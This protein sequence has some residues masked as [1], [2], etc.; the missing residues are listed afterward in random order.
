MSSCIMLLLFFFQA[1]DGIRDYKV[2]GVQTCALPICQRRLYETGISRYRGYCFAVSDRA[3]RGRQVRT[4]SRAAAAGLGDGGTV[5]SVSAGARTLCELAPTGGS[6]AS[7]RGAAGVGPPLRRGGPAGGNGGPH[8]R[9]A[10]HAG[11]RQNGGRANRHAVGSRRTG[12]V[13]HSRTCS[14]P[15]AAGSGRGALGRGER[16][17]EGQPASDSA[18]R[19]EK[20]GGEERFPV[21]EGEEEFLVVSARIR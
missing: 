13:L 8:G 21:A 20:R 3:E 15:F 1:E 2:T 17:R 14:R 11:S 7:R 6:G 18:G 12:R 19:E 5:R 10:H 16:A 9:V 4:G